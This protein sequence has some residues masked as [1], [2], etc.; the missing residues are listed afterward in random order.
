MLAAAGAMDFKNFVELSI[1]AVELLGVLTIVVGAP[2]A[3]VIVWL[4]RR[5]RGAADWYLQYRRN[6]GR[7]IL[8]G[9]EFL[10]AADIIRTVAQQPTTFLNVA[11]LAMVVL[12]RT[13]LSLALQVELE[14]R[15]PWQTS[16]G[17]GASAT[18]ARR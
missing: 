3:A 9:L 18:N 7:A 16:G 17:D 11:V 8:L 10:V 14:G 13:F 15:F 2:G 5:P 6:L 4:E 1:R 12:I